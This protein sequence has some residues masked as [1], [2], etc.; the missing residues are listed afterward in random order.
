M[1]IK[2]GRIVDVSKDIN[3]A[4]LSPLDRVIASA[5]NAYHNTTMYRRRYAETEEKKEEQRRRVRETLTDSLLS[6]IVPEMEG[7]KTLASKGDKCQGLLLKVPYRFNGFINE[8]LQ[9]HEFDA[10]SITIVPPSRS[11]A[12]F[13]DA[14]FLL[15]VENRGGN[16]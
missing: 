8:V 5:T 16:S 4:D 2:V 1:R 12:K 9:A 13:C 3:L 7:N 14:P 6:I 10:Y 11:I 15:Y